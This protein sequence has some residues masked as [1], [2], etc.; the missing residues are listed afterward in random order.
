MGCGTGV[1]SCV[2]AKLGASHV[3]AVE[4]SLQVETARALVAAN[5]LSDVVDV[6]HAAIEDLEP[7]PMDLVFSELL[8]AEP[9]AEGVL[10]VSRAARRWV[11]PGGRLAPRRL[12]VW[13]ALVRDA[14]SAEE[15]QRAR[16]ELAKLESA[17]GLDLSVV[18]DAFEEA[19]G[20]AYLA[21]RA[22]LAS[23]PALLYSTD[24]LQPEEPTDRAIDVQVDL[25]ARVGGVAIWFRAELDDGLVLE[26]PPGRRSHWGLQICAWP[27][28][29]DVVPGRFGLVAFPDGTGFDVSPR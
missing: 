18:G 3:V 29:V 13:V 22:D 12:E 26:N 9:F 14:G 15:L 5:G 16:R 17:H 19:E 4:P 28:V 2:A 8:N 11:A 25:A 24:L 21:E 6:R 10:D 23:Q 7:E 27:E 1:L 20:Y